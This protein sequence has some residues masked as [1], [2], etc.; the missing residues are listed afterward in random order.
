[1]SDKT[2]SELAFEEF[3]SQEGVDVITLGIPREFAWL[4]YKGGYVD[5]NIQSLIDMQK[6]SIKSRQKEQL[7][8]LRGGGDN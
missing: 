3:M 2:K 5:G 4:I 7:T 6:I 8:E 1:M